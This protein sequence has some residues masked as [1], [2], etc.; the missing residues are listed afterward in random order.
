MLPRWTFKDMFWTATKPL[1]SLV[2][3]RVSRMK[4]SDIQLF[5]PWRRAF[6]DESGHAF[7]AFLVREA[8]G[9]DLARE[10][11][12]ARQVHVHL[13]LEAAFP[14]RDRRGRLRGDGPGQGKR[15]GI[16]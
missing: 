6:V 12:G 3:P 5:L 9:D 15:F 10:R 4:S 1:N 2:K 11:V 14:R 8:R 16:E 13:P 7:P